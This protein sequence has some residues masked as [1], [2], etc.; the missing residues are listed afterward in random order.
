MLVPEKHRD[1]DWLRVYIYNTRMKWCFSWTWKEV[2]LGV[3]STQRSESIHS[4]IKSLLHNNS[5][6]IDVIV[7]M[8][9]WA[10]TRS[11]EAQTKLYVYCTKSSGKTLQ[12]GRLVKGMSNLFH[13]HA[14]KLVT[15]NV[16][17]SIE[18]NVQEVPGSSEFYMVSNSVVS[19]IQASFLGPV[20]W[21]HELVEG[22]ELSMRDIDNVSENII[23]RIER[24]VSVHDYFPLYK[25]HFIS[26]GI[27][28]TCQYP[29]MQG[30]PCEH[31]LAVLIVKLQAAK[32]PDCFLHNPAWHIES[33]HSE[34]EF[35]LW[36]L[37]VQQSRSHAHT[38]SVSNA[39]STQL[40]RFQALMISAKMLAQGYSL[41]L[42]DSDYLQ[43]RMAEMCLELQSRHEKGQVSSANQ[44]IINSKRLCSACG[45]FGH[46]A[47]NRSCPKHPV[48]ADRSFF[49]RIPIIGSILSMDQADV[50]VQPLLS[51]EGA[52][53]ESTVE[54]RQFNA[55]GMIDPIIED[56]IQFAD[57]LQKSQLIEHKVAMSGECFW[58]AF[59][60]GLQWMAL[61]NPMWLQAQ[62]SLGRSIP[63][64]ALDLRKFVLSFMK[65]NWT[66][67]WIDE[68]PN[69]TY[70]DSFQETVK[71][72]LSYGVTN[73]Q[74]G[75]WS[76]SAHGM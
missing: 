57:R 21:V 75:V 32:L 16:N 60:C 11:H 1:S 64:T 26:N 18:C 7:N 13:E 42:E 19:D 73:G 40:S 66:K 72:E 28:C 20:L 6:L 2:T 68:N 12:Q 54:L 25:S 46:R 41:T 37:K 76:D 63:K 24:A 5:T 15:A 27:T 4:V 23:K 74:T 70:P 55:S 59:L 39:V 35:R 47:D 17:R 3:H 14:I 49:N 62:I 22:G 51:Q 50:V 65:S 33:D 43:N 45:N 38:Q 56:D 48:N 9:V 31:C 67:V 44:N 61:R 58:L 36:C 10:E 52:S 29:V 30:L 53:N 8:E 71:D 34:T 69:S